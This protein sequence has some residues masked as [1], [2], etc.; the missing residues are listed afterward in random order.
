EQRD[1]ESHAL[2]VDER[3]RPRPLHNPGRAL[4]E[5][6]RRPAGLTGSRPDSEAG[7]QS[8]PVAIGSP[9]VF[10]QALHDPG[11]TAISRPTMAPASA[12]CAA[13]MPDPQ[14]AAIG[15]LP[16]APAASNAAAMSGADRNRPASSSIRP[17]GRLRAPGMCPGIGSIGSV[18][19]R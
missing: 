3:G 17:I 19:P 4:L 12:S 9:G 1:Q 10:D 16:S 13:V 2:S 8:S 6:R 11:Y 14:Y 7:P 18:S 15:V 5:R